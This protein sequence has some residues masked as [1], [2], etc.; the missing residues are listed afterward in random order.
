M[1]KPNY[2]FD[3]KQREMKKDKQQEAK[4]QK[5]LARNGTTETPATKP[6]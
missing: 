3:K 6:E 2:Q 5:K 1:A 4:R